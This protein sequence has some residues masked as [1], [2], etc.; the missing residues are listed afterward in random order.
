APHAQGS[1]ALPKVEIE[2]L[3][4]EDGKLL[5]V[6]ITRLFDAGSLV[7]PSSLLHQRIGT[8]RLLLHPNTAQSE[9]V[10]N[11]DQVLISWEG[12]QAEAKVVVDE[13]VPSGVGLVP[14]SMGIPPLQQAVYARLHLPE[15]VR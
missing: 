7:T 14:R 13:T 10:Q 11:G 12:H 4:P 8:P 3:R 15:R 1:A 5:L 2:A 6:P 9:G